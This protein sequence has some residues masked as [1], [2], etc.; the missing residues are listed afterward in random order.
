[1][2]D[3]LNNKKIIKTQKAFL[4]VKNF[5]ERLYKNDFDNNIDDRENK[6]DNK[7]NKRRKRLE[8]FKSYSVKMP[9]MIK[10]NGLI[11]ALAF[12][13][14]K[15]D[16]VHQYIY[17]SINDYYIEKFN[18]MADD[19]IKDI[20]SNDG[21]IGDNHMEYQRVVTA[22]IL[23]YLVWIKRFA[24]SEVNDLIENES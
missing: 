19:I 7:E 11:N 3:R 4:M 24:V 8:K 10:V 12:I 9:T 15:N 18:P 22:E 6:G 16:E 17:D 2:G 23:S 1:M 13:K 21:K 20:L 5:I 14:G